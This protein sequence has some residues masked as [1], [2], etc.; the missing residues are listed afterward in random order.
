[1]SS[2]VFDFKD[3]SDRV[4]Q[5]SPA[6]DD[7][8]CANC[9]GGGWECYGLGHGDPHFRECRACGNPDGLPSP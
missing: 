8:V 5:V 4:N 6:Q 1:M 9:E 3:I 7:I 2:I